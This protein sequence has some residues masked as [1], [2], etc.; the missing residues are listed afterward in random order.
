MYGDKTFDY[1]NSIHKSIYNQPIVT[2]TKIKDWFSNPNFHKWLLIILREWKPSKD[3]V[4]DFKN[5][6]KQENVDVYSVVCFDILNDKDLIDERN[7]KII[8]MFRKYDIP[9]NKRMWLSKVTTEKC[10]LNYFLSVITSK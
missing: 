4:E 2:D 6:V 7:I 9:F 10:R 3:V 1:I 8:K 5:Y